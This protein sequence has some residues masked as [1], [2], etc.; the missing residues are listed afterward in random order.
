[1]KRKTIAFLAIVILLASCSQLATTPPERTMFLA[2]ESS[3]D[4]YKVTMD[5]VQALHKN[6]VITDAQ[7]ASFKS[8]PATKFYQAL[9][10]AL[11]AA[12]AWATADPAAKNKMLAEMERAVLAY[13]TAEKEFLSQVAGLQK[14]GK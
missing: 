5:A 8:G 11:A 7:W 6:G 12:E 9:M 1:M 13:V 4:I 14:G 3:V 10:A 2:L